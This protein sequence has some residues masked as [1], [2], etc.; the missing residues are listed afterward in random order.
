MGL[1]RPPNILPKYTL[2]PKVR[3]YIEDIVIKGSIQDIVNSACI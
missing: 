3:K 2:R 1:H